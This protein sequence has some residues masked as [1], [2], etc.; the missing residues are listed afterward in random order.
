MSKIDAVLEKMRE[1]CLSLPDTKMTMTW[2]EPHFRVGEK[3]FAGCGSKDGSPSVGFKLTLFHQASVIERP[4]FSIAAYVGKHGW[5]SMDASG[6]IDWTEVRSMVL[7]S[8]GLIAPRRSLA[9]LELRRAP[10]KKK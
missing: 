5:V 3:I 1:I 4:E 10:A 7:E 6:K 9:K 8:Y 2:G